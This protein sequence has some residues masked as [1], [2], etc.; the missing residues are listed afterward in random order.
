[1]SQPIVP[2]RPKDPI[3]LYGWAKRS[4]DG[5]EGGDRQR[6]YVLDYLNDPNQFVYD[7]FHRRDARGELVKRYICEPER[8]TAYRDGSMGVGG[9]R[10]LGI[11]Q[12]RRDIII[13]NILERWREDDEANRDRM[14]FGFYCGSDCN[15]DQWSQ[16][17]HTADGVLNL[18]RYRDRKKFLRSFGPWLDMGL[19]S[20]I[21][22]DA[23]SRDA[24]YPACRELLEQQSKRYGLHGGVE[25]LRHSRDEDPSTPWPSD[26]KWEEYDR[27]PRLC[28]SRFI[29]DRDPA[30]DL[31]WMW[32]NEAHIMSSSLKR[33][34]GS[35]G[36]LS[37]QQAQDFT[38]RGWVV[39][40]WDMASDH[41]VNLPSAPQRGTP[42]KGP[43]RL[44]TSNG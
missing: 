21:W 30:N 18:R 19:L 37:R 36:Q 29:L 1:M 25:A 39:G 41:L 17:S 27:V 20:E 42:D 6:G 4:Q 22:W 13:W 2:V 40:A 9:S 31:T 16:S 12:E 32:W 23:G 10:W 38:N 15:G 5:L 28:V 43:R 26:I 8:R 34:D 44:G 24:Y 14:T 11:P 35:S 33:I 3:F 7:Q